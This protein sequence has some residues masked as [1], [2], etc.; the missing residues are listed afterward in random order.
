MGTAQP[1]H[2]P[3]Q[4]VLDPSDRE[5]CTNQQLKD[6]ES[7]W[8]EKDVRIPTPTVFPYL[9]RAVLQ[10][11]TPGI[12]P[13]ATLEAQQGNCHAVTTPVESR[14]CGLGTALMFQ[15]FLDSDITANGGVNPETRPA[16]IDNPPMQQRARR[17]KTIVDVMCAPRDGT[18]P[19]VCLG[20]MKG[21]LKAGYDQIFLDTGFLMQVLTLP[22]AIRRFEP[23]AAAFIAVYGDEWYF[24]REN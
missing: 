4:H 23:N 16:F 5:V 11:G 1:T 14:R 21:A 8:I 12:P 3:Q 6:Q 2:Y 7:F 17:C 20:Y 10:P 9:F 18:P 19:R 15:C 24:C 13:L 22:D